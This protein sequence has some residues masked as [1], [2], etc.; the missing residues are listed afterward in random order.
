MSDTSQ[1]EGTTTTTDAVVVPW[2]VVISPLIVSVAVGALLYFV[3]FVWVRANHLR[4]RSPKLDVY[5]TRNFQSNDKPPKLCTSTSSSS[6]NSRNCGWG[7]LRLLGGWAIDAWRVTDN[8]LLLR[9]GLDTFMFVRMLRLGFR[10]SLVGTLCSVVLL[11]LYAT[12]NTEEEQFNSV[13]AAAVSEGSPR[14]WATAVLF[15]G[16]VA[17]AMH[18][19]YEEWSSVYAVRRRQFLLNSDNDNADDGGCDGRNKNNDYRHTVVIENVPVPL[20]SNYRLRIYL[21]RLFGPNNVRHVNVLLSGVDRLEQLI[22]ERQSNIVSLEKVDARAHAHPTEPPP[23]I[24]VQFDNNKETSNK[25][26][27]CF[28]SGNGKKRKVDARLHY[29]AEIERLNDEIDAER[30]AVHAFADKA[31]ERELEDPVS[32]SGFLRNSSVLLKSLNFL[33]KTNEEEKKVADECDH[34]IMEDEETTGETTV[35]EEKEQGAD[36]ENNQGDSAV[37]NTEVYSTASTAFVTFTSLRAKQAAIQ[38]EISGKIDCM[39]VAPAPIPA[40]I[41]WNNALVP[42]TAQRH[43]S[44][45]AAA[46]WTV[47]IL[48]WAVPV[49]FITSIANLN[50]ILM[51]F[52]IAPLDEKTFYYGLIS[53]LLPVIFLQVLMLVLY[54]SIEL[55]AK[56]FIRSKSFAQVDAYTFFWHQLYQFAN[57]WLILIGGSVFNQIDAIMK[58]PTSIVSLLATALPGASTFFMNMIIMSTFL[59]MGVELSQVVRCAIDF[60]LG[61]V[62]SEAMKTQRMIDSSRKPESIMWG[63]ILPPVVFILLVTLVYMPIVPLME[64]FAVVYFGGWYLVYKHNCLHCYAQEFEGGGLLFETLSGFFMVCLYMAEIISVGYLG[65]KSATGPAILTIIVLVLTV[66]AHYQLRR[67]VA[68]P[69]KNGLPLEAAADIDLK[70]GEL[71]VSDMSDDAA[72]SSAI[73]IENKVFAQPCLKLSADERG[74]MPYRRRS[75]NTA[76]EWS[77]S[78]VEVAAGAAETSQLS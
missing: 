77:E 54:M 45:I 49:T 15:A 16:Y 73:A 48:F 4:R 44:M 56:R 22:D 52:G 64:V 12:G 72:P 68:G 51:S 31:H 35:E 6:N 25:S 37:A 47:G 74:P 34:R 40:S 5:E 66:I 7:W 59:A 43:S 1:P 19:L 10:I 14:F 65:L 36:E 18:S 8:D 32:L 11:P 67:N 75:S 71:S 39:D 33:K 29:E 78:G 46:V 24:E 38:C 13:T 42:A 2:S 57:L 62:Q 50:S 28:G 63:K 30:A 21:G 27:C 69:L 76:V 58:D 70:E 55:C 53:G 60:A 23:S 26:S 3:F 20:R 61:L 9:V 41:N 17:F